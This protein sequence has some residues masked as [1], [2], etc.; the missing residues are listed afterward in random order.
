MADAGGGDEA[1]AGEDFEEQRNCGV[2]GSCT[3]EERLL[4]LWAGIALKLVIVS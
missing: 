2:G 4:K 1:A 3:H